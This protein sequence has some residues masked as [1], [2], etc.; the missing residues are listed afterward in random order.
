MPKKWHK[1]DESV[2]RR[3]K[4]HPTNHHFEHGVI[5]VEQ[6]DEKA[7][8]ED[9]QRKVYQGR[10]RFN[11]PRDMIFLDAMGKECTGTGPLVWFASWWLS[12]LEVSTCP[13]LQQGC[14][15]RA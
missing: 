8:K 9:E 14:Q 6:I 7:R 1:R 15:H 13:L 11:R 3:Q 5:D 2:Y 4:C 12:D 10:Q